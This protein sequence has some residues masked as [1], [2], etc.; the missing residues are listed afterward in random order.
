MRELNFA[1]KNIKKIQS[2]KETIAKIR[3]EEE[4]KLRALEK[5][6][7]NQAHSEVNFIQRRFAL[8]D[9]D[10]NKTETNSTVGNSDGNSTTKNSTVIDPEILKER[11]RKRQLKIQK[12]KEQK[13][14]FEKKLAELVEQRVKE[15]P[16]CELD[17]DDD[18]H[19]VDL[20]GRLG[21]T[22]V[23][24]GKINAT[25]AVGKVGK[26]QYSVNKPPYRV[27]RCDQIL[28]IP[29]KKMDNKDYCQKEEAFMTMSIYMINFFLTKDPNLLFDSYPMY[30]ITQIPTQL[31]GA[32]DCTAW[33]TKHRSFLFCYQNEEVLHQVIDAYYD[34]L[35]CRSGNL[36]GIPG[37]LFKTCDIRK[38]DLTERGPFGRDGP[39]YRKIMEA[40]DPKAFQKPNKIDKSK[41]NPYYIAQH[42]VPVPGDYDHYSHKQELPRNSGSEYEAYQNYLEHKDLYPNENRDKNDD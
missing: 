38:L 29:G 3:A 4:A 12:E 11:E 14:I 21:G 40:I 36:L 19:D 30:E 9:F 18:H 41:I 10:T 24:Q 15:L 42:N 31:A 8:R 26:T 7:D 25:N 23:F 17:D 1:K 6:D 20:Y 27:E 39:K 34:F 33:V 37:M 2:R 13:I 28:L 22:N 5:T 32:P 16:K 35:K